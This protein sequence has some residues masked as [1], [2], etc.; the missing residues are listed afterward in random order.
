MSGDW[1]RVYNELKGWQAGIGALVG[2]VG[3]IAGA[4]F[5]AHLNRKRD[6]QLRAKEVIAVASALYG[7]AVIL[8]QAVAG[9]ANA[10]GRRYLDHGTGRVRDDEAFS[11]HFM[12]Q[13]TLP[14][15]LLYQSLAGKVGM[16]PSHITLEIVRFYAR[17]E[18]AQTWLPR[19]Q[20][21]AERPFSY[22]VLYVL[23]PA[24]DAVE[25]V[26][27]ALRAIEKL[28]GIAE[29]VGTPDMQYALDV[30]GMERDQWNEIAARD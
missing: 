11:R 30:Q 3:L 1:E 27:P 23:D 15:P 29:Q 10:V 14:P 20:E 12:E 13:Y 5:N 24:I 28:A 22:G 17:V 19:L 9:M 26:L 4:L 2:F 25:G 8:R 6:E 21:D 16:L 7:E 18:Q